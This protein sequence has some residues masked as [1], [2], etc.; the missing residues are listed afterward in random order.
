MSIGITPRPFQDTSPAL[1]FS[2]LSGKGAQQSPL[3]QQN[4][5]QA[6]DPGA[7]LFSSDK[8]KDVN[9]GPPDN[10]VQNPQDSSKTGDSQSNIIQLLSALLMSLLQMLMNPNKKQDANQDQGQGQAPS[11]NNGGLGTPPADSGAGGGTPDAAGG[12]GD[13]PSATGDGGG[14]GGTPGA[15]DTAS[16]GA[17]PTT[18]DGL[19]VGPSVPTPS[20]DPGQKA[21]TGTG[22]SSTDE[23]KASGGI[24]T[25]DKTIKV[26]AGE[27]YDGKGQTF[28]ASDALG[29]GDQSENQKPL[30]ELAEGAT[31][32]NVNM[33]ENEADGIHVNAKN[34]QEVHIDNLHVQN[35][36]EDLIT[37]K[38]EAGAKVTNLNIT[39]SSA[40]GADD[41]II[42]LNANTHLKVDGFKA[43]DFGTMV[44]TNG[45]KQFDDMS[46]ELNNVDANHGKF[47][48]VKSD[49]ED[50]KLT[51]G[52]IAMTDVKHAYDKTKAST[53]HTEL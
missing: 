25:V 53:Q 18:S 12:G 31:L 2:A 8:Q 49:S 51:T 40:K 17:T 38:G 6:I 1:D 9:F 14:G 20:T 35:V 32:K 11:Q 13:T 10:T 46:L 37:V 30:F 27:V 33:G 21:G 23:P 48:L 15:G 19:G 44:R 43:D 41:K 16:T 3:G 22:T 5:Q 26:G 39:N 52:N 24:V 7:L 47:A 42:Q 4:T 29:N 34:A 45:G 36:G 28:T 50:L